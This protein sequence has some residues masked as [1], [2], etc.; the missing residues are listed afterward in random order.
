MKALITTVF[1][2]LIV[3][4]CSENQTG[5]KTP[6]PELKARGAEI[7]AA[8]GKTL[9]STVQKHMTEGGVEQAIEF[10]QLYALPITDSLAQL[11]GVEIKRT[12]LKTR[13][14]INQPDSLERAFLNSFLTSG[15]YESQLISTENGTAYFE[16][17]IL[18]GF[19]QTCHG[20]P[21]V[22]MTLE[23]DAII[24]LYYPLDEATGFAEGDFRGMWALYFNN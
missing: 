24:K 20:T 15:N 19:C 8:I 18:K 16:P 6:N 11:H 4:S 23:T 13:N 7:T 22:D 9:V 14:S 5:N 10:C 21:R 2:A 3:F 1:I 17:I 12:A